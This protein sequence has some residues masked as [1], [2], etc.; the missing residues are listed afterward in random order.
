MARWS[1]S[2]WAV[3]A[4]DA[5]DRRL[6]AVA[7]CVGVGSAERFG[8]IGG[9]PFAV[10][11]VEAVAE[12]VAHYLV[13]HHPGMPRLG[14]TQEAFLAAGGLVDALHDGIITE[15]GGCPGRRG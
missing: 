7:F 15:A 9:E 8:P 14:E 12:G 4:V 10:L 5:N 11:G 2:S 1:I 6:V 3:A 13:D